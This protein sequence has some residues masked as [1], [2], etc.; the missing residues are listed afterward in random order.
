MF[1]GDGKGQ[2]ALKPFWKRLHSS[3]AKI[4]AVATD[5]S[6]AY[7]A[8]VLKNL[9]KAKLVFDRFHIVKLMNE[10]LSQLRRDLHSD[11]LQFRTLSWSMQST[12]HLRGL[13]GRLNPFLLSL[14]PLPVRRQQLE[15]ERRHAA[16]R[17]PV[18]H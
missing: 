16:D 4:N 11:Q 8:A 10:K 5:V 6:R 15:I 18:R 2:E 14:A 13:C 9:P 1:V 7:Y 17:D 3:R 12:G